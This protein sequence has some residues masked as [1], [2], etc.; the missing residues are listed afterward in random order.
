MVVFLMFFFRKKGKL[1][2]YCRGTSRD[3][4]R[5]AQGRGQEPGGQGRTAGL[6][7]DSLGSPRG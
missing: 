1:G 4:G 5:V 2:G 6:E 7:L 3:G